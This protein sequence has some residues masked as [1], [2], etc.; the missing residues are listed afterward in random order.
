MGISLEPLDSKSFLPA[1]PPS[2]TAPSKV[3][4]GFQDAMLSPA[5]IASKTILRANHFSPV[6]GQ[7]D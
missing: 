4:L 2:S 3:S 7:F 1:L 6:H 5:V